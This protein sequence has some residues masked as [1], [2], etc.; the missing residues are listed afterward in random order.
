M[1]LRSREEAT[2]PGMGP[3]FD[4]SSLFKRVEQALVE[5]PSAD[6]PTAVGELD[7][8][9]TI[10][11]AKLLAQANSAPSSGAAAG[12][13]LLCVDERRKSSESQ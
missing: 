10:A 4:L 8:L 2:H 5:L 1:S 9:K 13:R 6:C 12:D 11:W 3:S 7:R